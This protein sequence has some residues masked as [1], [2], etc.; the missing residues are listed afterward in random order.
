MFVLHCDTRGLIAGDSRYKLNPMK[1]WGLISR[2]DYS[3]DKG[4]CNTI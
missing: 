2:S 4:I 1:H 3:G